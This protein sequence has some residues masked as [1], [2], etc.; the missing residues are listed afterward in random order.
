MRVGEVEKVFML[1]DG[2]LTEMVS[3]AMASYRYKYSVR[4][5]R[6]WSDE[7]KLITVEIEGRRWITVESIDRHLRRDS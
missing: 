2:M 5:I 6:Q 1:L 4:T 7:G 3:V